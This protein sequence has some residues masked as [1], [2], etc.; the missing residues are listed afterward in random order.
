[1]H[2]LSAA[3]KRLQ[4]TGR[5]IPA[6]D[7]GFVYFLTD[8]GR[9]TYIGVTSSPSVRLIQHRMKGK[10]FDAAFF[11]PGPRLECGIWEKALIRFFRPRDN[12]QGKLSPVNEYDRKILAKLG[13][14]PL[15]SEAAIPYLFPGR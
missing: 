12:S 7:V 10:V 13:V 3:F 6:D 2:D 11:L 15:D 4:A 5:L 9:V 14:L 8:G 1:M